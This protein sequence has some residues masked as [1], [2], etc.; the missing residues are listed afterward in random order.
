MIL[1]EYGINFDYFA[2][3]NAKDLMRQ[4]TQSFRDGKISAE[5][6]PI[7]N[8]SEGSIL[9]QTTLA[10]LPGTERVLEFGKGSLITKVKSQPEKVQQAR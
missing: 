2:I 6:V 5:N 1:E 8:C 7:P 9:S 4:V 3:F 10:N